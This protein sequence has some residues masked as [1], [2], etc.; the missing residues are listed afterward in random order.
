VVKIFKVGMYIMDVN[1]DV[2]DVDEV[3]RLLGQ[4]SERFDVDFKTATIKESEEFEWDDD[5]KINRID[6]TIA[7][8]EE[9]FKEYIPCTSEEATHVRVIDE[10]LCG[11]A[12]SYG[13]VYEYLY[14]AKPEEETHYIVRDDGNLFYDFEC[15]IKV[16]YLKKVNYEKYTEEEE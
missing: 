11:T 15:V 9:Y 7:D 1:E 4:I 13:N 14:D 3:K 5:L 2:D 16:E 6:A 12:L 10:D 8:Y